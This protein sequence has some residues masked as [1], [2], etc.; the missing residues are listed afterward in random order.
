[1]VSRFPG[2]TMLEQ[3][4]V[5]AHGFFALPSQCTNGHV[6]RYLQ[7]GTLPPQDTKCEVDAGSSPFE[8]VV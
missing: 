8:Q 5:N 7:D 1:M 4:G 6:R 2:S 3:T